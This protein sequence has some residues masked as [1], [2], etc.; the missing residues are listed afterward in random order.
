MPSK[1]KK[2]HFNLLKALIH[3]WERKF[4][5]S[6]PRN[7]VG[8]KISRLCFCLPEF[9]PELCACLVFHQKSSDSW[10]GIPG[11]EQQQGWAVRSG[12]AT[13][14]Q[15]VAPWG[16][17]DCPWLSLRGLRSAHRSSKC[18]PKGSVRAESSFWVKKTQLWSIWGK[19]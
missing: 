9:S 13:L 5:F 16:H 18:L 15:V 1:K 3:V 17:G 2:N 14:L 6:V 11:S 10:K 7:S 19:V 4:P 12:L 8:I